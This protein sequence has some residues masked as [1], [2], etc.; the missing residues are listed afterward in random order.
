MSISRRGFLSMST[1]AALGGSLRGQSR[2]YTLEA[3]AFGKTLKDPNGR[4]VLGYLT[5]K[6]TGLEGNSACCIHPFNTLGGERAT[7]IAPPDHR[8]HRGMFF[9]WHDMTFSRKDETLRGDFWGWGEF[10]PIEGRVIAN[11]DVRLTRADA[12]SAEIAVRNDWL[13]ADKP[14]MQEETTILAAEEDRARVLDLTYRFTSDYD[15]TLNQMAFTGFCFRCR[16]DGD[17]SFADPKGDVKLPNS[18]ATRPETDW[19]ARDW[20]SHTVVLNQ[21]KPL[22]SAVIDHPGNPPTAWHGAR[23]VSFLNPC[24]AASGAVKIPAGQPLTLRYRAVTHDGRFPDGFL[25]RMA[26]RWRGQGKQ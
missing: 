6:P 26:A 15:V 13:I 9:A 4:V 7:D 2:A 16:K 25:N 10:A 18:N 22:A 8:N 14:V 11:R 17:Y 3:D 23:Y 5:S 1:A 12:A 20:Y 24:I 19:P 21:G